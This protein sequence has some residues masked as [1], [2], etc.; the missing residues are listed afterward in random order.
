MDGGAERLSKQRS[1]SAL[2]WMARQRLSDSLTES[3]A[4]ASPIVPV[5]IAI[6]RAN[7]IGRNADDLRDIKR[8][9]RSMH[10]MT[11]DRPLSSLS[12]D[13]RFAINIKELPRRL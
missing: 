1:R 2:S 3:C 10:Q 8:F 13:G 12:G 6:N 7:T 4:P 5:M 11:W 9:N